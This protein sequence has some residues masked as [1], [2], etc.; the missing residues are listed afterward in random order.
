MIGDVDEG[1]LELHQRINVVK[2][3]ANVLALQRRKYLN[4]EKRFAGGVF[5]MVCDFHGK[6]VE[7]LMCLC[8]LRA[9]V[10]FGAEFFFIYSAF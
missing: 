6:C 8:C 3:N 10:P 1:W 7:V 2:K 4:A 9:C 5:D